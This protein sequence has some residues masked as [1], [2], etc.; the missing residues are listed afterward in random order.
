MA[1][2]LVN[3]EPADLMTRWLEALRS[4][5][6]KQG[7]ETLRPVLREECEQLDEEGKFELVNGDPEYRYCCLGVLCD[8][9][10]KTN[11]D[12]LTWEDGGSASKFKPQGAE[13]S[14]F[15][16]AEAELPGWLAEH[17]GI[18]NAGGFRQTEKGIDLENGNIEDVEFDDTL[19]LLIDCVG[20]DTRGSLA[21][22]N[23]KHDATFDDIAKCIEEISRGEYFEW[24]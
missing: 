19:Q 2:D 9:V 16:Q 22:L 8:V 21:E 1:T 18:S 6:Y 17:L 11:P 14:R 3:I 24:A 4:G 15:S 20:N 12:K 5:E 10:L 13:A 23:D 7:Q